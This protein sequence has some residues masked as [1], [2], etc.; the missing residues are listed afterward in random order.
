L[1]SVRVRVLRDALQ[2]STDS[3]LP[4]RVWESQLLHS[5]SNLVRTWPHLG[6]IRC[7]PCLEGR[8]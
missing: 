4:R 1:V 7:S 5:R 8:V 3:G 6:Q 2:R